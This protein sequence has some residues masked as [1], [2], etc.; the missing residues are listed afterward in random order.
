M[1]RHTLCIATIAAMALATAVPSPARAQA[2]PVPVRAERESADDAVRSALDLVH[3]LAEGEEEAGWADVSAR[4]DHLVSVIQS[5]DPDN[6]WLSYLYAWVYAIGG[7]KGDA[8]ERLQGFVETREGRNEWRA[9]RLL[10]DLLV[11]QFPRLARSNYQKAGDLVDRE[12]S[13]LYGLSQCAMAT[14]DVGEAIR[15]AREAVDADKTTGVRYL[16]HLSRMLMRQRRWVEAKRAAETA[17]ERARARQ[18]KDP[19]SERPL[20]LADL[21]YQLLMD[22][23]RAR[24]N[25]GPTP[26]AYVRLAG[27]LMRRAEIADQLQQHELLRLL[28]VA[29]GLPGGDS[30]RPLQEQYAVSLATLERTEAAVAAFE[31]VLSLDPSNALARTW[32]ARLRPE[33]PPEQPQPAPDEHP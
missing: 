24:I 30:H 7:Q 13:V 26:E 31:R 5:D 11:D 15:L 22:I 14:G 4:M 29:V 23:T 1:P 12:A 16:S 27:Y 33:P 2:P 32:L 20:R 21:Q 6:P 28:E 10:G 8:I 17:L 19:T 3:R 25:E 9:F 18:R